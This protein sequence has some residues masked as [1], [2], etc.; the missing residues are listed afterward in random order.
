MTANRTLGPWRV[1]GSALV[2]IAIICDDTAMSPTL[3]NAITDK[4]EEK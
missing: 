1:V 3:R 4:K 2:R